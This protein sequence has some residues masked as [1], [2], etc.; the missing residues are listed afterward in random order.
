MLPFTAILSLL[1]GIAGWYYLFYSRAALRL[2]GIEQDK[3]NRRRVLLR[4]VGGGIMLLLAVGLYLGSY[5]ADERLRPTLFVAVW[6]AVMIL[7]LLLVLLAV[8]DVRLTYRIRRNPPG[9]KPRDSH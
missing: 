5:A 7:I 1:S 6:S 3:L 4:R 9:Q 2:A 8:I